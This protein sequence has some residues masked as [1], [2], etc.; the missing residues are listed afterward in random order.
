MQNRI[1]LT[2]DHE[3]PKLRDTA[4]ALVAQFGARSATATATETSSTTS[5]GMGRLPLPGATPKSQLFF[6][7][8]HHL[9]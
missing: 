7:F 5:I 1:F 2:V 8:Y 4:G 6:E 9:V 3:S